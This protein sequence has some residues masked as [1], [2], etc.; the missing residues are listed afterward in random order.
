M[1]AARPFTRLVL[2][3]ALALL[4]AA[5]TSSARATPVPVAIPASAATFASSNVHHLGTIPLDG[6]GVSMRIVK[7]GAQVR[8]FVSGTAGLSIYDATDPATPTLLGHLPIYNWENEDIAV[9][10]DG[11]T[12]ILTEFDGQLYL[13]V[14][15]VSNPLLPTLKGTLPLQASHTAECADRHCNYLFGSEG[16]TF[17]IRDRA[18]PTQLATGWGDLT[19]AGR[20]HNLH[21]DAAGIWTSD[22][23]PLV[24]FKETPD[25][26]HLTVLTHGPISLNTAYQHNNIRP[27]ANRYHPRMPG[28]SL[29]GPLRP[30]ELLLGEGETNEQ[31]SCS[32]G[33]GA[34]ATWS[35]AGFDR[36]VPMQQLHVLRPVQGTYA[37]GN[38]AVNALGCSGHWFSQKDARDGSILVAAAWYEHGTRF[39]KVNPRTGT[40]GQVGWFQPV[41]GST[42]AA[43]WFPGTDYVWSV[44]YHSG[45]DI[46]RFDQAA[47]IPTVAQTNASWLAVGQDAFSSAL[48]Q[49]CR[50]GARATAVDH[51][52]VSAAFTHLHL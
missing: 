2:P 6:S 32:G 21:Q 15:D 13:H 22:T 10:Q 44:D 18:H 4:G 52:R 37:D 11:S 43:Y 50:A 16:Q 33:S 35:M 1:P 49:L 12:A 38:A 46:L 28:E 39:L 9:S 45:I 40:I 27:R 24:V 7:V 31:P 29:G 17:D 48:R 23:D 14:I 26:L 51:A 19:G 25:P 42:S 20:G 3:V 5:L 47:A 8:A 36:G 41:R 34:F 30:G